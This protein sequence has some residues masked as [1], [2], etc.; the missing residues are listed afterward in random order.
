MAVF[1]KQYSLENRTA[2]NIPQIIGFGYMVLEFLLAIY[3]SGWNKL[4]VN[5]KNMTFRQCIFP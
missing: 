1:I 2:Q 4:M 3:E 5:K